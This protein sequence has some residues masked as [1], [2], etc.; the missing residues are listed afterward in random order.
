MRRGGVRDTVRGAAARRP[1][2]RNHQ[3]A[4][5][6]QKDTVTHCHPLCLHLRRDGAALNIPF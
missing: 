4:T 3:V 1:D 2:N 5:A 6:I